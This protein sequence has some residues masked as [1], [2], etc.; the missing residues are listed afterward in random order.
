MWDFL[1]TIQGPN[2][3]E[4]INGRAQPT[5]QTED[6]VFNESS[7]GEVVEKVGEIFPDVGVSIFAEALVV[8]AVDLRD[9]TG[10]VV[11]SDQRY[12]VRISALALA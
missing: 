8:E 5:V 4:G 12:S 11:T 1:N 10:F 7:E 3:V 2:V 9:L 6:L